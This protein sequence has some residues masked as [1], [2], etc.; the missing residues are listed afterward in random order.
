MLITPIHI[1]STR[2]RLAIVLALCLA[3]FIISV[4]VTIVNVALPTLVRSLGASTTQLQWVVDAYSLVFA[5]LVLAAGS[6]SD[7]QGRKGTLLVGL[8]VFASGSLA[9]AFVSTTPELIAARAVMG[10]GAALMFPSTLSLLVNVF[11]ERDERAKAIGLWG[12]TTGV[13]I[14]TGPIVGGWL[15]EHYW[16]GSIFTFMALIAVAVAVLVAVAVPTSRDPLTPRIDWSGLAL[17]SAAMATLILGVI[18]APDWGWGS[19]AAVV[20]MSGGIALFFLFVVHET[21]S[22]HPMLDVAL[23]RN[24]RFTAA[25]GSVAVS[26]FALQGFI[27]LVTQYFQ[28]IRTFSP[29]GTG[30]RLLPVAVPWPSPRSLGRNWRCALVT[31]SSSQPDLS[32]SRS[33]CCGRRRSPRRPRTRSSFFRCSSSAPVWALPARR[34]PKRSW[35][36][37]PRPS[38]A[39]ARR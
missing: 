36:R 19:A 5:A 2:S 9:G 37:F 29:L 4:D 22:D 26:F 8:M 14:A 33:A 23:F 13:G 21:R 34:P 7:R 1:P 32:R 20:T 25:S 30:V 38:R 39:L 17:S 16:W 28:F 27:F 18:E 31:R 24:P 15:L 6:L 3:A 10:L 12:A 35:G 11:T